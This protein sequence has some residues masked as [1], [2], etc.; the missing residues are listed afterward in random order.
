[1]IPGTILAATDLGPASRVSVDWAAKLAIALG[2]KIVIA[3]AFDLPVVGLPDASIIVGASAASRML[4]AAQAALDREVERVRSDAPSAEGILKQGDPR[5]AIPA[6]AT[7]IGAGLIVVG[8]H[9]RRGVV[10]AMVGSVAEG[11]L[12]T[13][14][15]PVAVVRNEG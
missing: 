5:E 8:S 2:A 1:M 15:V 10:R 7:E 4:D 3:H 11:I 6:L 12:R 9:G 14:S 13:S